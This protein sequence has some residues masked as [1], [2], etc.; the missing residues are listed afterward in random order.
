MDFSE[1]SS[2]APPTPQEVAAT[3]HAPDKDTAGGVIATPPAPSER[4]GITLGAG[5]PSLQS[6]QEQLCPNCHTGVLYVTRYDP[7]ALHEKGQEIWVQNQPRALPTGWESGG[8]YEV[9][10]FACGWTHSFPLNPGE[11]HGEQRA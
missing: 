7:D 9:Q 2:P 6:L 11:R 3:V 5:A 1:S 4:P 8:A 10:C